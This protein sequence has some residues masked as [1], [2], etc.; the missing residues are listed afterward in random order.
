MQPISRV[1]VA[2]VTNLTPP[3]SE[4]DPNAG[5]FALLSVVVL[6]S[7]WFGKSLASLMGE[8][9]NQEDEEDEE[10]AD[11]NLTKNLI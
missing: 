1:L 11:D 7:F 9:Q 3:G 4:C 5:W 6:Y 8:M 2:H 10:D